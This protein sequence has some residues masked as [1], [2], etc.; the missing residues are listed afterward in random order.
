[1][2]SHNTCLLQI[3]PEL[4]KQSHIKCA[5]FAKLSLELCLSCFRYA[6]FT[7][8]YSI[9]LGRYITTARHFHIALYSCIITQL[10]IIRLTSYVPGGLIRGAT[11]VSS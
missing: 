1:M 3:C 6:S 9:A 8:D 5:L 2:P 11:E 10:D 7:N 4:R